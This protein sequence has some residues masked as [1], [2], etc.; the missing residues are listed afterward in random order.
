MMRFIQVLI[1]S[2]WKF[3]ATDF[4]I[5]VYIFGP[6]WRYKRQHC[7]TVG[8]SYLHSNKRAQVNSLL[9]GCRT[10]KNPFKDLLFSHTGTVFPHRTGARL[11]LGWMNQMW[12]KG[13]HQFQ[14]LLNVDWWPCSIAPRHWSYGSMNHLVR[15]SATLL[16]SARQWPQRGPVQFSTAEPSHQ[17][18]LLL[19]IPVKGWA[20]CFTNWGHASK[21]QREESHSICF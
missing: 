21:E 3:K 1:I 4:C 9:F 8:D 20:L 13:R 5:L 7:N 18:P 16:G 6:P 15:S 14:A 10:M 19:G 2:T 11:L 12:K 17:N